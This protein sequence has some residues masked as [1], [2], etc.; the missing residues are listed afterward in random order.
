ME[1]ETVIRRLAA[2]VIADVVGYT[3]LMERDDTG[4]YARV[5]LI[6]DEVVDPAIVSHG[7]R[8][9]K[10][11]DDG[12]VAEFT[13]ALAALRASIQIQRQ[14]LTRNASATADERIDYRIGVNLGDIMVEGNDIAGDGVN[15]ASRLEALA[16]PG[17]ICVSAGVREQVH[18]QLDV[19]F[20]DG[21][22][23]SVKNIA[24][25][26]RVFRVRLDGAARGEPT[27]TSYSPGKLSD[28]FRH[29]A[30]IGIAAGAIVTAVVIVGAV[31]HW[32]PG[33]DTVTR[34]ATFGPPPRSIM[35]LP[36]SAPAGDAVLGPLAASLSAYV[37]PALA[38]SMRDARVVAPNA[39]KSDSTIDVRALGR[40]ANVRYL[41]GGDLHV[42]GDDI[43]ANVRLLDTTS[44]TQLAS[45]RRSIVYAR[46]AKD[47]DLLV[48]RVT[49]AAR[50]MF[51][52]AEGRRVAAEPVDATD[53]QSLIWRADAIFTGEDLASTRAAR[54]LYE[55][56]IQRNP[57]L[58][59][60]WIG[61]LYTLDDEHWRDFSAGRNERL[62]AE[63]DADSR[64]AIQLDD[65]DSRAWRAR[66]QALADQWQWEGAFEAN[67]RARGLDPSR[68]WSKAVLYILSGRSDQ[69]L[70]EIAQRNAMVGAPD[71]QLLFTA[72]HAHLH[73][74]QYDQALGECGR[75]VAADNSY[76]VQLDLVVAYA[77]TGDMVRAKAAKTDLMKRVPDFT[78]ARLETKQFSN[79]PIW[80]EEIRTRFIPGLRKAGVPD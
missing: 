4:T 46:A 5:R 68:F 24:R 65:R 70:H 55:R 2:I 47:D 37:T 49:A 77:Q 54:K 23:Q 53:A 31:W 27:P 8:I 20:V 59:A 11:A 10:T 39:G 42:T 22:E 58:I 17:G 64:R 73:L 41:V 33:R 19:E 29:P 57:S 44:G 43:V 7:G 36:F 3:R 69:A 79:N 62:L 25:P 78:I 71:S 72:C 52:D 1:S 14:M 13:S 56:A 51:N 48:A 15:V 32:M 50:L 26:I 63:M 35:V 21:G 28:G 38:N 60:A 76:G 80:I 75:A 18:G 40:D 74:G 12:L 34:A 61:H 45:E 9:V 6:R 30:R 16:E 67:D 66:A